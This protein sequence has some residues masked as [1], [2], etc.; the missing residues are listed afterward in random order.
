MAFNRREYSTES[1]DALSELYS[2]SEFL[3]DWSLTTEEI[4]LS[5][6]IF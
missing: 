2:D 5:S 3:I 4:S 6:S 1:Y